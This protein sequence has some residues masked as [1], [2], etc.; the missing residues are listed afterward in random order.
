[1]TARSP[2]Y[3]VEYP[4]SS[5]EIAVVLDRLL[6]DAGFGPLEADPLLH[7]LVRVA[8]RY[9]EIVTQALNAAP[10]R[11]LK[12][13]SEFL[14]RPARAVT[15]ARVHV[16]FKPS[17]SASGNPVKVPAHTQIAGR[18]NG[19]EGPPVF[20]TLAPIDLVRADVVRV[21]FV[22]AGH[23]HAAELNPAPLQA[24]LGQDVPTVLAPVAYELH[25][26][27]SAA[28]GVGGLRQVR[29]QVDV[30]DPGSCDPCPQLEWL[31][32]TPDGDLLLEIV[33][34]TTQSLMRSGETE[35]LP[36][37]TWPKTMVDG[38][39]ARWLTLRC[40]HGSATVEPTV[41]WRAP[42]LAAL[43]VQITAMLAEQGLT[44]ACH[45]SVPLDISKD[46]FP[47]GEVPRFGSVFQLLCPA[48]AE[49]GASIEMQIQLTNPIGAPESPI[50]PV[51]RDGRPVVAWEIS[52][53]RGFQSVA[54]KDGTQSL[55]QSGS[56]V[57][58][59]R[60]DVAAA[61]IAGQSGIWLR[62]RLVSGDYGRTSPIDGSG[63][64]V[65]RAPA[66]QS[67][68]VQSALERGP[69][70][71]ES[72]ISWGALT[73][74]RLDPAL[75][76]AVDAFPTSEVDG[77]ALYI[78]L[79]GIGVPDARVAFEK[80]RTI[81]WSVRPRLSASPPVLGKTTRRVDAPCWQMRG[82][83]GWRDVSVN[84][85]SAGLTRAGIVT[86]R[87]PE[88]PEYWADIM[89]DE[90]ASRLVWLRLIWP[91]ERAIPLLPLGLS[92]NSVPAQHSQ[93]LRNEIL[94]SSNGR[95]DQVFRA[96][97]TPIIG[98]VRL[99]VREADDDWT[100]WTEV[101]A[102]SADQGGRN[103]TLNRITGELCFGDGR[104]G[105]IPPAGPNNIR[106]AEYRT[107]GGRIGNQPAGAITQIRSAVPAVESVTN[108]EPATGGSDADG[109][110]RGGLQAAAWLRHR[111]RAVCADDFVDLALLSSADVAR[112]FC[113]PGRD[114]SLAGPGG[115]TDAATQPGV[116][117]LIIIPHSTDPYPQPGIGLLESVKNY[118][119]LR[120]TPIGR[121]VVLGPTYSRANV[122]IRVAPAPGWPP[123]EV[124]ATCKRRVAE[125]LHPLTGGPFGSGWALGQCPHRS[126]ILGLLDAVD[127]IGLVRGLGLSIDVP[128]AMPVIIAAGTTDLAPC[129]LP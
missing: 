94:G 59:V 37:P 32:R 78:G 60:V 119:D 108:H 13:F 63:I 34:D 44:V 57:F 46:F 92:M 86:L 20:E 27:H 22:D 52:T 48:F 121:L 99:Q 107:G 14:A 23:R 49:P 106:L 31:V 11:H 2:P 91:A 113:I 3:L 126:D 39:E 67:I 128:T 26:A 62:A 66:I 117:S 17:A 122:R 16:S 83:A 45:N 118:L 125:F 64:A 80:T 65:L 102:L 79:G 21:L 24:G 70:L 123:E 103:F 68:A 115:E 56:V 96:L 98:E 9:G 51:T 127:G 6:A 25:I 33:K 124:S 82:V 88:R 129:E 84:D 42:R 74:R 1:M 58:T 104:N 5:Q 15:A 36:P 8:A 35:L 76:S 10:D 41:P 77:P 28:F 73:S 43:R 19:A 47:F 55:T 95:P 29:I 4:R 111:D 75:P 30:Q 120:R 72:L 40:T 101:E 100:D 85:E 69:M 112:A 89:L 61:T 53:A 50:P 116:V 114:L 71:P 81:C 93:L 54:A 109:R 97:R 38:I 12:V 18:S 90:T 105:D 110:A 7:A 87:L